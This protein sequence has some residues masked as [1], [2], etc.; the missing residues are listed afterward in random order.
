[1]DRGREKREREEERE[2]ERIEACRVFVEFPCSPHREAMSSDGK[3]K[4]VVR[5]DA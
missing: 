3:G 1:M 2:E 5:I 4:G